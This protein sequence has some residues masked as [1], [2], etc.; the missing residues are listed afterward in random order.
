LLCCELLRD[1]AG[2][3]VQGNRWVS[4]F[5]LIFTEARERNAANRSD[6]EPVYIAL[7]NG[8]RTGDQ[9]SHNG[10]SRVKLSP[11]DQKF[12]EV[13]TSAIAAWGT[14]VISVSGHPQGV[15]VETWRNH[16][17]DRGYLEPRH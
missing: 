11:T 15:K 4:W 2:C 13:L 1:A 5:K 14:P 6:F 8:V 17:V 12:L 3:C 9:S 10:Q 7:I 16:L